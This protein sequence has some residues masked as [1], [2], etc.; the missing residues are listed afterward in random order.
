SRSSRSSNLN[1]TASDTESNVS[2]HTIIN[3]DDDDEDRI[4]DPERYIRDKR[5]KYLS[6]KTLEKTFDQS[7]SMLSAD[8][9]NLDN[10]QSLAQ[11]LSDPKYLLPS[12][13]DEGKSIE[14]TIT[15]VIECAHFYAQINDK[16]HMEDLQHIHQSLN[17]NYNFEKMNADEIRPN[18]LCVTYYNDKEIGKAFYRA[19]ILEVNQSDLR[20]ELVF[21][22]YGIRAR[23]NFK[24]L[25]YSLRSFLSPHPLYLSDDLKEYP[26]QAL[27]CKI[28]NV[29]PSLFQN[30]TGVWT[31]KSTHTFDKLISDEKCDFFEI[32]VHGLDENL[33]YINLFATTKNGTR[34]DFTNLLVKNGCADQMNK[35]EIDLNL[36]KQYNKQ[37]HN[38][39][40]YITSRDSDY[41][42]S[43]PCYTNQETELI[44]NNETILGEF[45]TIL[46]H[47]ID[48]LLF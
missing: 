29:K 44:L 38:D 28:L 48:K 3:S 46:I 2:D 47:C 6:Y 36:S 23:R 40:F 18:S 24:D 30:P 17:S 8:L 32:F 25:F 39:L 14:I 7:V 10:E 27:E 22:D 13:V 20:V 31:K 11:F 21:I 5:Q 35:A 4:L 1:T 9:A 26:C 41:M 15:E 42:P 12:D 45:D 16:N 43:R 37:H 34:D 33:A 19:R